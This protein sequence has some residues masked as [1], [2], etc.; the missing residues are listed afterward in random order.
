[1]VAFLVYYP[2]QPSGQ[3]VTGFL[4]SN[5][6]G[7]MVTELMA[8]STA[9]PSFVVSW[10][11]HC[12]IMLG[13]SALVLLL[14][15]IVVRRAALRQAMGQP[16]FWSGRGKKTVMEGAGP[17]AAVRRVIG[18]PILWKERRALLGKGKIATAIGVLLTVGVLLFTYAMCAKEDMLKVPETHMA[19][20]IIFT[21]V[22]ILF[23]TVVPATCVTT[24]RES[25]TWPLLLTTTISDGEILW[26]KLA[27]AIYRCLPAWMLLFGHVLVFTLIGTIHPLAL[28]QLG[29]LV[30]W[31]LLFLASSGLFFSLHFRHTTTAVVA[32]M[33]LA[34]ALWAVFPL[35]L[36]I[37][38]A[39]A[40]A[41]DDLLKLYVDTNPFLHA[42]IIAAATAHH[43]GLAAYSWMQG[44]ITDA[45]SATGWI[46]LTAILYAA[47]ATIFILFA[48]ARLRV[49]PF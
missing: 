38:L 23:T 13:A 22:G 17:V 31:L 9:R 3:F 19:Y 27:G 34:A 39:T 2:K 7:M 4:Y 29:I 33:G 16:G 6:Y 43:G 45:T 35:L 48:R 21:A 8:M 5:P 18:P 12:G 44:G 25:R 28:L 10:P 26:G 20:I 32:N 47:G 41:G 37:V 15:V 46:V 14:T 36:G 49:D 24:E 11:I 1:M 30:A 40:G 42:G